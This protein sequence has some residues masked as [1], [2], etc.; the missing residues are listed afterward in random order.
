MEIKDFLFG[1]RFTDEN[2]ALFSDS[3]LAEMEVLSEEEAESVW[4][5]Y[6]DKNAIPLCSFAVQEGGLGALP[7]LIED[8]GWG[9]MQAERETA[10][11]LKAALKQNLNGKVYVC[12]Y[13]RVAVKVTAELFCDRWSDF[14]YPS[15]YLLIHFGERALLYYE[16]IVFSLEKRIQ[17]SALQFKEGYGWK[18][19]YDKAR[20]IY[21][22]ERSGNGYYDLYEITKE[23]FD[24]LE[25]GMSD[26]DT[27]EAITDG[28]HLYKDVNDRCGPP[29]TIVFDDEYEKLCP[30]AKVKS[31][32]KVWP[33]ELTDAAVEIFESEKNN[34]EQRRRKRE[35]RGKK[36]E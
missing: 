25:D 28:R 7:V 15:D 10:Q 4:R 31:S 3:E 12:Y 23:T 19:C 27:F 14:C 26:H 20:G 11:I 21:T 33:D 32:G 34:R 1:F 16:D 17:E 9:D 24:L 6:C 18:A 13:S 36:E 29:Y 8:C 22:A 30:W 2:Y 5:S 35:E